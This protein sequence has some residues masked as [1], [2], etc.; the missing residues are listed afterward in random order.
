MRVAVDYRILVVG[1][2]AIHRGMGRFT[3]QQLREVLRLDA[4]NEYVLVCY[5]DAD[6][7]LVRSDI[8]SAPNVTIRRLPEGMRTTASTT[9]PAIALRLSAEF[10]DW[11]YRFDLDLFHATTPFLLEGPVIADFD[12]CPMVATFYDVIPLIFP[13]Q[14]LESWP[15]RDYYM[16]TLGLLDGAARLQ[17]ISECSQRDAS[18]YLGFPAGRNDLVYP[19]ADPCFRV[20]P[21][22]AVE[23]GMRRLRQ[24]HPIGDDFVLAVSDIHHAKN[25]ESLLKAFALLPAAVR[26][27]L[28]LVVSCHLNDASVTYVR[29]L[30]ERAGIVADLVLTG[31]VADEELASLYNAATMVVHPSKY[32]GFGLPVLEAMSCGTPVVTTSSSS[33]PEVA[34]GAAMLVGPEDVWGFTDAI[35]ELFDDPARREKMRQLGLERS[36]R[37]TGPNLGRATLDSYRATLSPAGPDERPARPRV[38]VWTPLP[39]Q[40]SGIA[41]YSAELLGEL[42]KTHELEVFVD[43]G[44]LPD[45]ALL[46]AHRIQ[47]FSAFERRHRQAPFDSVVYQMGGSLFH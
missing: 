22:Q 36:A 44:Y 18:T 4:E 20:M 17:S 12:V 47:H 26:R 6:V 11:L 13:A 16:R 25:L 33:L 32:E 28:P 30:A 38:A 31:V 46:R 39:P 15:G 24:R 34:G 21:P 2:S 7:S 29:S 5:A 3:Q 1:P 42:E 10:Q 9:E 19:V 43:D 40:R 35:Q 41:D 14:Y 37:F 27:E 23:E 45:P 8:A